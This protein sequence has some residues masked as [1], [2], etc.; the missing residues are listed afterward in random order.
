MWIV[1]SYAFSCFIY[2]FIFYLFFIFLFFLIS[3][4][5]AQ[6]FQFLQVWNLQQSEMQGFCV[7]IFL[8]AKTLSNMDRISMSEV[9]SITRCF[10]LDTTLAATW[11]IHTVKSI[12]FGSQFRL[13]LFLDIVKNSWGVTFGYSGYIYV[14]VGSNMCGIATEATYPCVKTPTCWSK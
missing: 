10:S 11:A 14:A 5:N 7:D 3:W 8:K 12:G 9:S 6:G 4:C 13:K 2:F 1:R